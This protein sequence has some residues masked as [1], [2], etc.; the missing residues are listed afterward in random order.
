MSLILCASTVRNEAELAESSMAHSTSVETGM[1]AT[2]VM[3]RRLPE[4]GIFDRVVVTV[5]RSSG[6]VPAVVRVDQA[7]N[8]QTIS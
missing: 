3:D 1:P 8:T 2:T 5:E 4:S 6:S 7:T